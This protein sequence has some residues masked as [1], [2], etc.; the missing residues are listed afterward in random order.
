MKFSKKVQP[1][2]PPALRIDHPMGKLQVEVEIE[3]QSGQLALTKAA[4]ARTARLLLDGNV[5]VR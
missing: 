3:E 4:L 2:N 5:Y 1:S